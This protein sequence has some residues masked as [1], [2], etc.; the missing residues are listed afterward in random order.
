MAILTASQG[1]I[2]S[3]SAFAHSVQKA[4]L[5]A[6]NRALGAASSSLSAA[7]ALL[8]RLLLFNTGYSIY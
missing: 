8:D 6:A 4:A 2:V 5:P 3:I 7:K 1:A